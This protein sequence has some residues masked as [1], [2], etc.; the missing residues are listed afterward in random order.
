[1][2]WW[3]SRVRSRQ[4]YFLINGERKQNIQAKHYGVRDRASLINL[5]THEKKSRVVSS[6]FLNETR[7]YGTEEGALCVN[8]VDFD[9]TA[10]GGS[11]LDDTI[12]WQS[13]VRSFAHL[14]RNV[15]LTSVSKCAALSIQEKTYSAQPSHLPT[16][17][18]IISSTNHVPFDPPQS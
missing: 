18:H 4:L 6:L 5:C 10:S 8:P 9:V 2:P 11:D 3:R 12:E 15:L 7:R 17:R 16:A 13:N 1:M 14:T